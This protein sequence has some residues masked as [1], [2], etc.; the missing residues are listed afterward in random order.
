MTYPRWLD[1][2]RWPVFMLALGLGACT[3]AT[4]AGAAGATALALTD[5][6]AGI[7]PKQYLKNNCKAD[8]AGGPAGSVP[9]AEG[10]VRSIKLGRVT[11]ER[12]HGDT[13]VMLESTGEQMFNLMLGLTGDSAAFEDL[14]HP[15]KYPKILSP[16]L[17]ETAISD[18]SLLLAL[19]GLALTVDSTQMTE[20]PPAAELDVTLVRSLV[21]I[22]EGG[23]F[24]KDEVAGVAE[25]YLSI[26]AP[27]DRSI[28][29]QSLVGTAKRRVYGPE[30]K[31]YAMA[32]SGG[33]CD[34]MQKLAA[35]WD[36]AGVPAAVIGV[37]VER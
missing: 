34:L 33:W 28:W 25:V 22:K 30:T 17:A 7:S 8:S 23:L 32:F 29:H 12:P 18:L 2:T 37:T 35:A 31:D 14:G 4:I 19:R 26:W 16:P 10:G 21:A 20:T 9:E 27:G 1:P 13:V 15:A 3:T 24:S 36:S 6:E 11:D 5:E